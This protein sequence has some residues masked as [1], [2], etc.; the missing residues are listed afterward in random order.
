MGLGLPFGGHLTH[1]W[2]VNF[3]GI[4]YH[5]SQ[6]DV[7]PE[8]HRVDLNRAETLAR[9][10]KPKVIFCGGTAYPRFGITR[11]SRRSPSRSARRSSQ[12]SRTSRAHRRQARTRI[13]IRTQG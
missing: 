11:A 8:T 6:Y 12:T 2:G 5:A 7:D 3:S 9:A 1:G 10:T 4:V 13:R